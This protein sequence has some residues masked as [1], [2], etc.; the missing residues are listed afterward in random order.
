MKVLILAGGSGSRLWPL[1]R[2]SYPKQFLTLGKKES[3]LQQTIKRYL[4]LVT[5]KDIWILTNDLYKEEVCSQAAVVDKLIASQ[6]LFEPCKRNTAPAIAFALEYL[7]DIVQVAEDE[8][9]IVSPSDHL[10]SPDEALVTAM[11][12][13]EEIAKEGAIVTFGVQPHKPETGYGYIQKG[14]YLPSKLAFHVH[15]FVEKPDAKT[16]Q[17]YLLSGEF[18]WNSGMFAFSLGFMME[19]FARHSPTIYQFMRKGFSY[20]ESSFAEMPDISIDYAIMERSK[21]V[22]VVPLFLTWSDIGSW[23]NLY[24]VCDKDEQGNV[25]VGEVL[26]LNAR[27]N[28]VMAHNRQVCLLGVENLVIV[29]SPDA[30][31]IAKFGEGEQVKKIVALLEK[32]KKSLI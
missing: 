19:E 2:K 11:Q 23:D 22:A 25:E 6:V 20:I 29:D 12:Q 5:S 9:I 3:F 32:E 31:L 17:Q 21:S 24:D 27:N 7:R 15:R 8:V 1:S 10:V 14:S 4:K 26:S 28:L 13:A 30:L 18:L 16:A